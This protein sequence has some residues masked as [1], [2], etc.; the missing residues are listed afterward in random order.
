M[1]VLYTILLIATSFSLS[2]QISISETQRKTP[3]PVPFNGEFMKLP[4]TLKE[5]V[6][7]GLV[8]EKVTL[9]DVSVFNMENLDGSRVDFSKDNLFK[10]RTFEVVKYS[11]NSS[12][13]LTI[14]NDSGV[15]NWKPSSIDN[16]V[17]N[18]FIDVISEKLKGKSFVPLH[19]NNE[20]IGL[21]GA[22][23]NLVGSQIYTIT[24]VLFSKFSISEYGIKLVLNN[25]IPLKYPAENSYDQPQIFDGNKMIPLEGW[26]NVLED[27]YGYGSATLIEEVTFSKF[28]SENAAHI[29]NIRNEIISVGMSY[30]Q[31]KWAW[32]IPQKSYGE[33]A[34]YDE[35]YDWGGKTLGFKDG[36]LKLIK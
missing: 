3:E 24:D 15:F 20:L 13:V 23:Y 31:C 30:D 11:K 16:Y 1:K 12:S 9:I 32:G 36:L 10:N 18:K 4:Y 28:K 6:G 14:S 19:N 29:D 27:G 21:D 2:S 25:E 26:I 7:A 8:G 34:G 35:V 17:F 33:M 22:T 5:E